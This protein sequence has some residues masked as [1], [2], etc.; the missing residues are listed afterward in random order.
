MRFS[1]F[2]SF[3]PND[4]ENVK[5]LSNIG[6]INFGKGLSDKNETRSPHYEINESLKAFETMP[7]INSAVVQL[8]NF[9]IYLI[10]PGIFFIWFYKYFLQGLIICIN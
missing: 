1:E 6:V 5:R 9:I 3:K 10:R 8:I 7:I 2:I 4:P